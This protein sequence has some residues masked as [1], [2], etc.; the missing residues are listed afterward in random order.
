M[1]GFRAS[2]YDTEARLYTVDEAFDAIKDTVTRWTRVLIPRF[3]GERAKERLTAMVAS[4]CPPQRLF[5]LNSL[6]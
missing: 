6:H 3:A 2:L 1:G 4:G 5:L